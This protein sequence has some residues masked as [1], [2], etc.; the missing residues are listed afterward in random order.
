MLGV[1]FVDADKSHLQK[2]QLLCEANGVTATGFSDALAYLKSP[3]YAEPH[4]VVID[5]EQSGC[6]G[7]D[8]IRSACSNSGALCVFAMT[9]KINLQ[10]VVAATRAGVVDVLQKPITVGEIVA[11]AKR[12]GLPASDE[13]RPDAE[14]AIDLLTRRERQVLDHLRKG[15]STKAV[16][17]KLDVSVRTIESH[18]AR[19]YSKFGVRGHADL[20]RI[21]KT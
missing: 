19:L 7:L 11:A 8:I 12:G 5:L 16:A 17:E 10:R 20:I 6:D 13:L 18:K 1:V 2:A 9:G 4:V 3:S 21:L 14:A 15:H